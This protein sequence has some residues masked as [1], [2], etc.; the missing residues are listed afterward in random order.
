MK[1]FKA[2]IFSLLSLAATAQNTTTFWTDN[3]ESTTGWNIS[4]GGGS[5]GLSSDLNYQGTY[6]F[7]TSAGTDYAGSQTSYYLI[8]PS[9]DISNYTQCKLS[10]YMKILTEETYDGGYLQVSGDNGA[11]WTK[12]Y[13]EQMSI[14]YDGKLSQNS[15]NALGSNLAWYNNLDWTLLVVDLDSFEGSSTLKFRFDFG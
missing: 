14:P 4:S 6:C 12:M 15:T 7:E 9:I 5:W 3:C 1:I 11:T 2:L 13:N 8:S 10:V